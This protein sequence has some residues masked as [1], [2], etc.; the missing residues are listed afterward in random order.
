[1]KSCCQSE[2]EGAKKKKIKDLGTSAIF[3]PWCPLVG[4]QGVLILIF[5]SLLFSPHEIRLKITEKFYPSEIDSGKI[6]KIQDFG[7]FLPF[8]V[9]KGPRGAP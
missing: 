8:L 5:H 1:M 6:L 2:L 3:G 7:Q 9:L 4:P